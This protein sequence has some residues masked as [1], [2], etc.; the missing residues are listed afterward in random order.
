LY[1]ACSFKRAGIHTG[2]EQIP[3]DTSPQ[4]SNAKKVGPPLHAKAHGYRSK[5]NYK[6]YPSAQ[7]YFDTSR[8][9]YF[10]LQGDNWKMSASLPKY[11]LLNL[12]DYVNIEM[13]TD[14]PYTQFEEHKQKFIPGQLKK[15]KKVG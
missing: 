1:P 14:R 2:W 13:D 8:K 3:K 9:V 4:H 10:Y 12:A 11:I 5:Y 15:K 7:V 6:F